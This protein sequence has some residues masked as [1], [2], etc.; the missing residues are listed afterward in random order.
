MSVCGSIDRC[1]SLEQ[2]AG[3]AI[4][5]FPAN[6]AQP[7]GLASE[8]DVFADS[9]FPDQRQLLIDN[10]DARLLGVAHAAKLLH[11]AFDEDLAAIL[12]VRIDA[13]ENFHQRRLAGAV[14]T[15]QRV[16][17][18]LAADRS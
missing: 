14:F 15:D 1:R 13:A 4:K 6:H 12:R 10:C 11:A 7:A 17:L 9:H 3:A 18:T 16:N 2:L 5:F 8:K